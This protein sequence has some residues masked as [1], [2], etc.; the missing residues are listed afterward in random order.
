MNRKAG[1]YRSEEFLKGIKDHDRDVLN[2]I[3][4]TQFRSI[5]RYVE[6]RHGNESDAW[7][8][9]QEAIGIVYDIVND[10][11]RK[12]NL[13]ASFETFFYAIAKHVWLKQLR[14]RSYK[15][16]LHVV[17]VDDISIDMDEFDAIFHRNELFRI[18]LNQFEKLSEKCQK[19]IEMSVENMSGGQIANE[20]S[21]SSA[22]SAYNLKRNC[23]K[24]LI[25][26]I[27]NDPDYKKLI[28]YEKP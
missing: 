12:L 6:S 4:K 22:Q 13:T 28:D 10:E 17:E 8:V 15:P 27:I 9:F 20:L 24:K 16:V 18:Y 25:R 26:L 3:Y 2:Y 14:I 7:D 23:I 21:M 1:K 11:N 19:T 5:Q